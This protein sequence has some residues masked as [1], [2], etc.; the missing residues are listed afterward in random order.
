MFLL[1]KVSLCPKIIKNL[2]YF[3]YFYDYILY[4]T[5]GDITGFYSAIKI[6]FGSRLSLSSGCPVFSPPP[7]LY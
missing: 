7:S 6:R 3:Y 2:T 1:L 5:F 4:V